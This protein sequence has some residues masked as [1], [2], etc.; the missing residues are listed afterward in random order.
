MSSKYSR[1]CCKEWETIPDLKNW[2]TGQGDSAQLKCVL[3]KAN[4]HLHLADFKVIYTKVERVGLLNSCL[5]AV[6]RFHHFHPSTSYQ[7]ILLS[8][9]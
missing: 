4:L 9:G 6:A 3:C 7:G 5:H 2:L 8:G 1:Q